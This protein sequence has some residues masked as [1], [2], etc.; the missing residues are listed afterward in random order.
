MYR[1]TFGEDEDDSGE[2]R[3]FFSAA[4]LDQAEIFIFGIV[5]GMLSMIAFGF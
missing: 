5:I 2:N 1:I 4:W 3:E